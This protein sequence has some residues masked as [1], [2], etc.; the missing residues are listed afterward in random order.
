MGNSC[1]KLHLLSYINIKYMKI[2]Q[3]KLI[4]SKNVDD[5]FDKVNKLLKKISAD[6]IEKIE[7]VTKGD[8]GGWYSIFIVFKVMQD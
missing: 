2:L 7:L 5:L 4:K 6:N 3:T 1:S 8:K